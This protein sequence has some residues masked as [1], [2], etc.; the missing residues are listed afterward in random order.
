[1]RRSQLQPVTIAAAAGAAATAAGT[2]AHV[3]LKLLLLLE[4]LLHVLLHLPPRLR[5][6]GPELSDQGRRAGS[7]VRLSSSTPLPDEH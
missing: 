4:E 2:A 5:R 6:H 3:L 1:M 7:T